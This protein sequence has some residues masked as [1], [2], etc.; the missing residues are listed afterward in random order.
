VTDS[1]DEAME[2]IKAN[3]VDKYGVISKKVPQPSTIL[4]E[5]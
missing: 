4:L 2:Y 1:V 3:I 5:K